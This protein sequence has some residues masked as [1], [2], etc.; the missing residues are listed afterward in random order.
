MWHEGVRGR[1]GNKIASRLLRVLNMDV[2]HKRNLIIWSDNCAGQNKNKMV[3]Y[4]MLFLVSNGVFDTIQQN[5]LTSGHSFMACDRDFALIEKRKRVM[6]SF[7]PN[8]LHEVIKLAKYNP[9][10][11]IVNMENL[12]F[13]NISNAADEVINTKTLNISRV[14]QIRIDSRK[15]GKVPTKETFNDLEDWK[16][17]LVLKKGKTTA[18]LKG[19]LTLLAQESKITDNKKKSLASMIPYLRQQEH[20]EFYRKLLN[21]E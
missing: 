3:V 21:I 19:N 13:F 1:G 11:A 14:V 5:F 20:K 15:P 10:F 17:T 2:T 12:G 7:V 9:P 16:E 8:D 6:K 4:V 18:D